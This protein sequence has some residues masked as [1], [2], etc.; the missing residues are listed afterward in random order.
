MLPYSIKDD[1]PAFSYPAPCGKGLT[2]LDSAATALRSKFVVDAVTDALVSKSGGVHRSVNYLG[3]RATEAYEESRLLVSRWLGGLE[4]EI[5][6]TRNTTDGLNLISH[7]W[8]DKRRV[9]VSATDHHSSLLA[10]DAARTTRVLPRTDG[11]VDEEGILRELSAGD[12]SLVCI[13]HVS[14]VTGAETNIRR[15]ADEA[16]RRG[17]ILVVDAAQSAPHGPL[18]VQSLD[19]DFLAFSGHKL[20][21]PAGIGVLW[22][23]ADCLQRIETIIRGGGVVDSFRDE[24]IKYKDNPWRLE[25]GTPAIE[26]VVG[27]AAAIE[28]LR[29]FDP[30]LVA[31]HLKTL[32]QHAFDLLSRLPKIRLLGRHDQD[33]M[34]PISFQFDDLPSHAIAR[35]LSDSYGVCVRSGF[36]CAEPLHRFIGAGPTIRLSFFVYNQISDIDL[37]IQAIRELVTVARS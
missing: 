7:G 18:D 31:A 34:G 20:G 6:F 29:N 16:H 32:R 23:K 19:C 21:A 24:E 27:L 2:Y 35:G 14:N 8:P 26:A 4:N 3:D 5:V 1:F 25:P 28:Y 36:H 37:A 22:G 12:V 17:A 15:L 13:S 33:S 11:L 10:W 30:D 9:L